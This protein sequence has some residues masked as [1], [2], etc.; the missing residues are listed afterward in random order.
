MSEKLQPQQTVKLAIDCETGEV[1]PAQSLLT[2]TEAEFSDLRRETLSARNARRKGDENAIRF[3]CAICKH[4]L[5]FSRRNEGAKNRWFV[6]DGKSK[7]CPWYEGN[8]LTPDQTKALIYRGQQEGADHRRMKGFIAHW[9]ENDPAVSQVSQEQTTFSEVV[10]GEWRRPDIRCLYRGIP[11]VFE[12]QLSYTFLSDVIARDDF[13]RREGIFIIWVFA[14]FDLSRAAVMDEAFFNRRNL[15]VLDKDA[16]N[17]TIEYK[18]LTFTGHHQVPRFR[19]NL[20]Q[21]VWTSRLIELGDVVF[22]EDT[23]RPYF[24]DYDAELKRLEAVRLD[25]W[26]AQQNTAWSQGIQDYLAAAIGYCESDYSKELK[27]PLLTLVDRLYD[28]H[29]WH[30]GYEVLRDESFFGYHSVLP[31]LLS[32]R[33]NRPIGYKV[34]SVFQVIE[35]GLRSSHRDIGKHAFAILYLWAYKTYRPHVSDTNRLWLKDYAHKVKLSVEGREITYRRF[36]G[37]DEAIELLFIEL[38]DHLSTEFGLMTP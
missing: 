32:I 22:S 12:I 25:S 13:Y 21:D 11:L 9:L 17:Q 4:P 6:H 24:F 2:M 3:M 35:S 1:L 23:L 5:F 14:R 29:N 8:R 19:G 38:A 28:N 10:K 15:F 34:K 30:R 37:F 7:N 27:A 16:T 20:V 18:V 31:A 36:G 26:Q 33:F